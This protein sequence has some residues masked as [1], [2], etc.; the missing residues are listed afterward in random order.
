MLPWNG[1]SIQVEG[2]LRI[3]WVP[4]NGP[5]RLLYAVRINGGNRVEFNDDLFLAS[6]I[7]NRTPSTIYTQGHDVDH[8]IYEVDIVNQIISPRSPDEQ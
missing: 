6:G 2:I 4:R 5:E 8:R 7:Q 3:Y 1:I